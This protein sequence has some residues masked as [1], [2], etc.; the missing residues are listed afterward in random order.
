MNYVYLIL[1]IAGIAITYIGSR[2]ALLAAFAKEFGE[3]WLELN[4]FLT[5][6]KEEW[7]EED[8]ERLKKEWLEAIEAAGKLFGDIL[9]RATK[10]HLKVGKWRGSVN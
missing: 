6:P 2:K 5:I 3:A 9:K 1:L 4:R 7:T 8:A 10:R